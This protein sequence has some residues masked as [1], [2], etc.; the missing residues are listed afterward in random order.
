M[1][2]LTTPYDPAPNAE[3]LAALQA[4]AEADGRECVVGA[5]I[6]DSSGRLFIQRRAP[7]VDLFP[8]CWDLPGGHVEPGE[9]LPDALRREIREETG[10]ELLRIRAVVRVFDWNAGQPGQGAAKREFDFL[11]DVAGDLGHPVI[12]RDRFTESRW[13]GPEDLPVVMEGRGR[14]DVSIYES[15]R[16]ALSLVKIPAVRSSPGRSA[17]PD[18]AH[19]C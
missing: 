2:T 4:R 8:A 14:E 13:I 16:R 1:E 10:W 5:L 9:S 12:E 3:F 11:V 19:G 17:P 6:A 7:T 18:R 15:V